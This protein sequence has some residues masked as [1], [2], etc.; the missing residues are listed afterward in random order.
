MMKTGFIAVGSTCIVDHIGTLI[1]IFE[2]RTM[3]C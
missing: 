3:Y 2:T 1:S